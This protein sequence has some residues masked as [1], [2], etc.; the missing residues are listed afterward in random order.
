MAALLSKCNAPITA[1]LA[2]GNVIAR[3]GI[4]TPFLTIVPDQTQFTAYS[5]TDSGYEVVIRPPGRSDLPLPAD[6]PE[7]VEIDGKPAFVADALRIDFIKDTFDRSIGAQLDPPEEVITRAVA[8]FVRRFRYVVRSPSVTT[9]PFPEATWRLVF[10]DNEGK[11]AETKPGE[12]S[13]RAGIGFRFSYVSLTPEVWEQMHGL[14]PDWQPPRW[15]DLL[16][17]AQGALPK[18]GTAVVL[19]ATALEVFISDTLDEL[20]A[21][22]SVAQSLWKWVNGEGRNWLKDPSPEEQFDFLLKYFVGH[23]LKEEKTLWD[24]FMNLKAARN[25]FVHGGAAKVGGTDVGTKKAAELVGKAR[26]V[27]ERIR[28]WLP[29]EMQ[30]PQ[31]KQTSKVALEKIVLENPAQ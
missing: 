13:G 5:Y 27:T 16:L 25:S 2:R 11:P 7:K 3:L 6:F 22:D 9:M 20:A 1:S 12:S 18:V 29:P 24:G 17:D 28:E 4:A 26:E 15:H 8:S 14:D 30:W 10:L 21:K 19:G 31:F 23:S